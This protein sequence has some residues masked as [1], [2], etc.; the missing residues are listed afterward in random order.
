MADKEGKYCQVC[1][2]IV[3]TGSDVRKIVVDGKEIGITH[4]DEIFNHVLE[5]HLTG[6][7]KIREEL[8]KQVKA[9]NYVPTKKTEAY[10][11]ALVNEYKKLSRLQ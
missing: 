5:M 1:G 6:D 4:L 8:L 7:T 9:F 3:P 10:A 11:A 2:G